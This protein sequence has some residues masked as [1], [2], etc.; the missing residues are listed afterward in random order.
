MIAT[1]V[2]SVVFVKKIDPYISVSNEENRGKGKK[3][4]CLV[5]SQISPN[6][7]GEFIKT[8][9]FGY[10]LLEAQIKELKKE[11]NSHPTRTGQHTM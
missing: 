6:S 10:D 2:F 9:L 4:I 3:N 11:I 8:R 1:V 7:Y 5:A